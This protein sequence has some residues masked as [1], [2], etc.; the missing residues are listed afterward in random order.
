M[1]YTGSTW[2]MVQQSVA[3]KADIVLLI[4]LL[5]K[6]TM[7]SKIKEH[8]K[9]LESRLRSWSDGNLEELVKEGRALQH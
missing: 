9:C 5:Q 4:L 1:N 7:R 8:T 3:L 2:L 6:P